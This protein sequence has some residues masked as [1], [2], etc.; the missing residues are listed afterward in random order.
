M[1]LISHRGNING[2]IQELENSPEYIET[3]ITLGFD[4]EVDVRIRN[5]KLFLGHDE[6][7]FELSINFLEKYY[8]KLWLHCKEIEVIEKFNELDPNGTHLHYF[9][10]E[11]DVI[12]LTSKGNIWAYPGKQPILNSIAVLPEINGDDVSKCYGVCSDFITNYRS[13]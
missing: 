1:K 10:H 13:I 2:P 4:V 8:S 3:A 6:P 7:Q 12:T 9:W 11:N 5:N